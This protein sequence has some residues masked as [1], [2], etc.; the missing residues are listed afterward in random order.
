MVKSV[1]LD[2]SL[3]IIALILVLFGLI[4]VYSSTMIVAKERQGDSFYFFKRQVI[5]LAVGLLIF[6]TLSYSPYPVY[7][8]PKAIF[9][10]FGGV[11]VALFAVFFSSPINHTYRW[12]HAAGFSVQPSEFAKI[13]VVLYLASMCNRRNVDINQWRS[14]ALILLPVGIVLGL[15]LREPDFGS[16]VLILFIVLMMLFIAGLNWRFFLLAAL[17]L[18]P[19]T[20]LLVRQ[21]PLRMSRIVSF[22]NPEAYANT[23]SFQA[24]QSIYA[25]GSGGLFGQGL[26]NSTQKLFF[27]PY[28]YTD[29]IFAIIC[30]EL[31][32][33]GALTVVALFC[34]FYVRG[35]AVAK[36]SDTPHTYLLVVGL[37]LL[38]FSQALINI[39]VAIGL[40]PTK[41]ISLPFI[42]SGGTS[43]VSSLLA[44]A[45]I[46]N[47]SKHRKGVFLND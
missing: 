24:L 25:V 1:G 13:A 39:S 43:L 31:G 30:E 36:Q 45:I 35:I 37:T 17:S 9:I 16:F 29:F 28:A 38:V 18:A 34:I 41:G 8:N 4:M 44:T 12:I 42:S 11:V 21:N 33:I 19:L 6:F 23:T 46:L 27:L 40:F 5:W 10:F 47:V 2:R 20:V 7:M 15:V 14:L 22:L 3:L 26:G 32:L